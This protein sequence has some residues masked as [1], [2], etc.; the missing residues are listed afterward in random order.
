[1]A[2]NVTL[3]ENRYKLDPSK[4]KTL[5]Q[6]VVSEKADNLGRVTLGMMWLKRGLEMLDI[7]FDRSMKNPTEELAESFTIAYE[8]TL[9]P[10]H[11]MLIKP[12]FAVAVKATPYR[13]DFYKK[14]GDDQ[15]QLMKDMVSYFTSF[16][17]VIA[18]LAKLYVDIGMEKPVQRS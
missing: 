4:N 3:I 11:N 15:E 6:L 18:S 5:Q 2:G 9:K 13:K 16:S 8:L 7:V 10:H 14:L 12:L 17:K 1:M